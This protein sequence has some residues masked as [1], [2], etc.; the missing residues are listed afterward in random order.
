MN[1]IF[2]RTLLILTCLGVSFSAVAIDYTAKGSKST[3]YEKKK[4]RGAD[5]NRCSKKDIRAIKKFDRKGK[6]AIEELHELGEFGERIVSGMTGLT[7]EEIIDQTE[8][9]ELGFFKSE[10]YMNMKVVYK[11]CD[12]KMPK[13]EAPKLFWMP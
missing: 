1:K 3:K 4:S 12:R 13:I 11:R 10:K 2:F 9:P 6:K 8:D 7:S 5:K